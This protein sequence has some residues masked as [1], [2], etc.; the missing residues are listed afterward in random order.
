MKNIIRFRK[1]SSIYA[2]GIEGGKRQH[3][4]EQHSTLTLISYKKPNAGK[5]SSRHTAGKGDVRDDSCH[6]SRI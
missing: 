1:P 3:G 4:K 2:L 5:R 6:P